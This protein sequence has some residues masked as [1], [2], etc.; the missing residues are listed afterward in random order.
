VI[1]AHGYPGTPRALDEIRGLETAEESDDLWVLH[2]G[3]RL[4]DGKIV[5]GGGR[6]LTVAALGAG[7][8][9]ARARAYGAASRIS[10]DGMQLR[11]DVAAQE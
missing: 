1:A 3:T 6:V 7:P 2:A 11:S 4:H 10:F 5:T 9:Q 8:A